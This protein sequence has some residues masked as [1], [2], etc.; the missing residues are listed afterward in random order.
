MLLESVQKMLVTTWDNYCETSHAV[1]VIEL[2]DCFIIALTVIRLPQ[3]T[4]MR[5]K[6][7][8]YSTHRCTSRFLEESLCPPGYSE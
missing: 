5:F 4:H 3:R 2:L 6:S 7:S 1:A 8:R